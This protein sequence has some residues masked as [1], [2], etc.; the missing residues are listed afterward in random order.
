MSFQKKPFFSP[1]QTMVLEYSSLITVSFNTHTHIYIYKPLRRCVCVCPVL[2]DSELSPVYKC[3][4]KLLPW[5]V[6]RL[7]LDYILLLGQSDS[8]SRTFKASFKMDA[9]VKASTVTGTVVLCLPAGPPKLW[10]ALGGWFHVHLPHGVCLFV[11]TACRALCKTLQEV[12]KGRQGKGI[13]F[14]LFF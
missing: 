1:S 3:V 7:V 8:H 14:C 4:L 10:S 5:F 6:K 13:P 9:P 11:P 2:P 12:Q